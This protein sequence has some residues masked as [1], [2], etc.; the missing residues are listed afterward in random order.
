MNLKMIGINENHEN[1]VHIKEETFLTIKFRIYIKVIKINKHLILK[2]H[3]R[4]INTHIN[5]K[6]IIHNIHTKHKRNPNH[7]P[8][9]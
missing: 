4:Y 7:E 3:I 2:E 8:R 9:I 1:K 5:T 6:W